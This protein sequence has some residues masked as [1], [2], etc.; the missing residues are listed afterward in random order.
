MNCSKTEANER[1]VWVIKDSKGNFAHKSSIRKINKNTWQYISLKTFS[2]EARAYTTKESADKA[3]TLLNKKNDIAGFELI[4]HIEYLNLNKII[5]EHTI[6]QGKN[7]VVYEKE[8]ES[9]VYK[10]AR[11]ARTCACACL[12]TIVL[13]NVI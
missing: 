8:V 11:V 9:T 13:L 2:Q 5:D 3:L 4:F 12:P 10:I 7:L 6:F 1:L